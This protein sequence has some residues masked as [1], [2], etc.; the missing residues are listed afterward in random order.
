MIL[1]RKSTKIAIVPNKIANGRETLLKF[2]S[3]RKFLTKKKFKKLKSNNPDNN[4]KLSFNVY[5]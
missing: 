3:I 4:S 2:P 1:Q 5:L